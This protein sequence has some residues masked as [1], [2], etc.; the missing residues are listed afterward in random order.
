MK[1]NGIPKDE[2]IRKGIIGYSMGGVN[3]KVI[4]S[5]IG[6]K[7]YTAYEVQREMESAER[8]KVLK[9]GQFLAIRKAKNFKEA[10]NDAN[11]RVA[12]HDAMNRG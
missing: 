4:I 3:H 8:G 10:L 11:N 9:P 7:Y 2:E 12:L 1:K 6:K 5:A